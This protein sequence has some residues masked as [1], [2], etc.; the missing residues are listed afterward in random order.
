MPA[1]PS[2]TLPRYLPP[3]PHVP[4]EICV[5]SI[6]SALGAALATRAVA[7]S[8]HPAVRVPCT[9]PRAPSRPPPLVSI[10]A[11]AA[12]DQR[13]PGAA[14]PLHAVASDAVSCH[15][16]HHPCTAM[17]SPLPPAATP[18]P[19]TASNIRGRGNSPPEWLLVPTQRHPQ[20]W[21][22]SPSSNSVVVVIWGSGE[23]PDVHRCS[24]AAERSGQRTS[25]E[26]Q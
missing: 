22:F 10:R 24:G 16:F 4:P 1:P 3:D 5:R 17:Q 8:R 26:T 23:G 14:P 7:S 15:R 18:D 20:R 2:A 12:Y 19:P 13:N 11:T 6:S 25:A 9:M 21:V